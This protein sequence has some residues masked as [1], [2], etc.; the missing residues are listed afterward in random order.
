MLRAAPGG[1]NDTP[2]GSPH[3]ASFSVAAAAP[4]DGGYLR[5]VIWRLTAI[6]LPALSLALTCTTMW[7][8]WP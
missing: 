6:T 7:P 5:I 8:E 2:N 1:M 4:D 3:A